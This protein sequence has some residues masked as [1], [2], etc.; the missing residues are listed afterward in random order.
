MDIELY[1]AIFA[2]LISVVSLMLTVYDKVAS[3]AKKWR[4][5]EKV[6]MLFG[7]FGGATVMYI[8]MQII[9]HKTKHKKFMIGL[10]VMIVVHLV[11]L[12]MVFYM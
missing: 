5:P 4:I 8:T 1:I 9:R 2:L 10:P 6:L 11:L 7:F 12:V 3:M